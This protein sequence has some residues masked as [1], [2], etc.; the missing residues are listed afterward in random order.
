M[1]FKLCNN[2]E[3]VEDSRCTCELIWSWSY[4]NNYEL[5]DIQRCLARSLKWT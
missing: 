4:K 5:K 1:E 2:D 3:D